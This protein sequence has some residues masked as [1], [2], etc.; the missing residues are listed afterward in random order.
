MQ[1][2]DRPPS[3]ARRPGAVRPG[4]VDPQAF[5]DLGDMLAR[6]A[7]S[8]GPRPAVALLT[9]RDPTAP[10]DQL[11]YRALHDRAQAAASLLLAALPPGAPV[12]I[13]MPT[14]IGTIVTF[15]GAVL[16]GLTPAILPAP[17]RGASDRARAA[18]DRLSTT[19]AHLRPGPVGLCL[20]PSDAAGLPP[21]IAAAATATLAIDD[22]IGLGHGPGIADTPPPLDPD[23]TACLQFTSGSTGAPRGVRLSHRAILSN[24]HDIGQVFRFGPG[25][26]AL[27][28]LPLHHDMGLMGHLILPLYAGGTAYLAAPDWFSRDPL[29]WL[30]AIDR[31]N[32]HGSG[33]PPFAYDLVRR[34]LSAAADAGQTPDIDLSRWRVAHIG[35]EPVHPDLLHRV[36]GA[37]SHLG[38]PDDALLPC[39]G[40]AEST[41]FC[42][43]GHWTPPQGGTIRYRPPDGT[44]LRIA[45]PDTGAPRPDGD[46]GE[47]HLAS[48]SL[49]SGHTGADGQAAFPRSDGRRWLK[50]GDLGRIGPDGLSIEGRLSNVIVLRGT[51]HHAEDLEA[52]LRGL[53]D[54]AGAALAALSQPGPTGEGLA[55]IVETRATP[56]RQDSLRPRI[57]A[58]LSDHHDAMPDRIA[59]VPPGWLPRTTSGKLRRPDIAQRLA[60]LATAGAA[61]PAAAATPPPDPAEPIAIIGL[62][63][64]FPGADD[65][66]AFW[67]RLARGD[68]LV[69]DI[70][71]DRWDRDAYFD[72]VPATPGK[73]NGKRGGFIDRPDLFDAAFFG[74]APPEAAE[75]D[76]QQRLALETAWRAF[77]D[78]GLTAE[79]L[80][81]S[82][83][84]V[85]LGLST[86]DYTYLQI[87]ARSDLSRLS[88]WSGLGATFSIAANR[89]SYVCDLRGPSVAVDTACS[90]SATA[91]HMAVSALRRGECDQAVAGGVNLILTPGTSIALAQFGM[92]SSD[93]ACKV[94]DAGADG[95]VR[96]EGCG[97]VVLKPLSRARAD[98]D[99]IDAVIL[100][101]A[102]A[103][104]GRSAGITAPNPDAQATLIARALADAGLAPAQIGYVEAHGTGTALGDPAELSVID[105]IYGQATG[106]TCRVGSV[107]A[108]VGHLEAAAGIASLIKTIGIF[109]RGRV[110]PQIHLRDPIPSVNLAHGRLR[111]PRTEEPWPSRPGQTRRAALSSFGFGGALAHLILAEGDPP[112]DAPVPSPGPLL[113]P[114]SARDGPALKAYA[115]DLA[116]RLGAHPAP[117]AHVARTLARHRSHFDHRTALVADNLPD[118]VTALGAVGPDRPAIPAGVPR[119]AVAFPGQGTHRPGQG[120]GLFRRFDAFR[121]AIDQA[122]QALARADPDAPPLDRL[123]FDPAGSDLRNP[124]LAQPALLALCL[125]NAALWRSFGLRPDAVLG[126]SLGEVAAATV[127]GALT[128]A[129]AMAFAVARGRAMAEIAAPGAMAGIAL[130]DGDLADRLARWDLPGLA[131]AAVNGADI[132]TLSGPA[133]A[134]RQALER[135]TADG[136]AARPLDTAQA[137]HSSVID[138]ALPA[139]AAAAPAATPPD[140]PLIST[141]TGA[142]L[143]E[144]PDAAHWVAHARQPVRFERALHALSEHG[145]THLVELGPGCV[146]SDL[147][148][149]QTPSHP[150]L[151]GGPGEAAAALAVLGKLYEAGAEIDWRGAE[152]L[153]PAIAADLRPA[154]GLP[155]HPFRRQRHWFDAPVAAPSTAETGPQDWHVDWQPLPQGPHPASPDRLLAERR[156]NWLLLGDGGDLAAT[157]AARLGAAGAQVVHLSRAAGTRPR[158]WAPIGGGGPG[159]RRLALPDRPDADGLTKLLIDLQ[160]SQVTSDDAR[161]T[162]LVCGPLDMAADPAPS[163]DRIAADQ[164][165]HG[166]GPLTTL[167]TALRRSGLT[168]Q[169][170]ALTRGAVATGRPAPL[171]AAVHGFLA[172]LFLEH[173]DL[174]GGVI[175]LDP[176][177]P[178]DAPR[179]DGDPAAAILS[180]LADAS[181]PAIGALRGDRI[182]APRLA[183][184]PRQ[185]TAPLTLRPDGT[186]L[187]TG[188]LGGLGLATAQRLAERGA[189]QIALLSRSADPAA[190][191]RHADALTRIERA[192]ADIALVPCDTADPEVLRQAVRALIPGPRPLRGI[193]HAAGQ[194]WLG[195]IADC[196]PDRIA[197]TMRV[198]ADAA[199]I[200]HAETKD[201]PLDFFVLYSSVSGLW[202]SAELGH[203]T[204]ANRFLDALAHARRADGLTATSIRWGP[205]AD[206]GMSANPRDSHIV[207]T[208]GLPLI[209]PGTALDALERAV[210]SGRAVTLFAEFDWDRFRAFA[211][212]NLC[213]G[214]FAA[215]RDGQDREPAAGRIG[216]LATQARPEARATLIAAIRRELGTL[217]H[218]PSGRLV[219]PEERFN[220]LGIDSLSAISLALRVETLTGI[221]LEPTLAY[222]HP[223]MGDVA[224][225]VLDRLAETAP[226]Q[227]AP[228]QTAPA[229]DAPPKPGWLPPAVPD[230]PLLVAL[231]YAGATGTAYDTWSDRLG[232]SRH[233]LP[234]DPPGRDDGGPG[235]SVA[236]LGADLAR[237]LLAQDLPA[238]TILFGH[239]FGARIALD[240]AR[241]LDAAGHPPE[242]VILSGCSPLRIAGDPLHLLDDDG[243]RAQAAKHFGGLADPSTPDA[244]WDRMAPRLRADLARLHQAGPVGGPPLAAPLAV[245]CGRDDALVPAGQMAAWQD[246]AMGPLAIHLVPGGHMP[247]RDD[248]DA[249]FRVLRRLIA[250]ETPP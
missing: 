39:Y 133:D 248:P 5:T 202:G 174:R 62:A 149:H 218:L 13:A 21:D 16:A 224:D 79:T 191:H 245:L 229:P 105:A 121:D 36:H 28:W 138:P 165:R 247:F 220:L 27:G 64:R 197:R 9:G 3:I 129:E 239:S 118:L 182:L 246:H 193:V 86:S 198:K 173:P 184:A 217:V 49:A 227:T 55:I 231:P 161:W 243:L 147:A 51:N 117:L 43:A 159:V 228:A 88:A 56:D 185:P 152:G 100:G 1:D 34:R 187:V 104:D 98:G 150:T 68:D 22:R 142:R 241:A 99:R 233:L 73:M 47:I 84:G 151:P 146:L 135:L 94:F 221:P 223:T 122:A 102:L 181:P 211:D 120:A 67:D 82:A 157:L 81:G 32:I 139:I 123:L 235:G 144:A 166:I 145:I 31:L 186:Y 83:T 40:L 131:I 176:V 130:S 54:L 101:S 57:A 108:S 10:A 128:P 74:I 208:M 35:A 162:I 114:L 96:S 112:G 232:P 204:A 196:T 70:P 92:L 20:G 183:R 116:D 97:M 200:L 69:T 219:G 66:A 136:I 38:L 213:P 89:V 158:A 154:P 201:L 215:L 30:R 6:R 216:D 71:P 160:A 26:R 137:F 180:A 46:L 42:A 8:H 17:R 188:G 199:A 29:A 156:K 190:R 12:L 141:L 163:P 53:P 153:A 33:G 18:L 76:P 203:Y 249:Y 78:A 115:T 189:G 19:L 192:G 52:T 95:Y 90:S 63:C 124:R 77:E 212:F 2:L 106:T 107:K 127:A 44:T 175:D 110:P 75:M 230:G 93:G 168:G 242:A 179:P 209:P 194:N 109:R 210:A 214:L 59:F 222:T 125:A 15:L 65:P 58:A 207:T 205:W 11:S 140:L 50:T 206:I 126:H 238:R 113:L 225:L 7:R 80:A 178:Q 91:L 119:I 61:P 172:S 24:M 169:V 41:V 87:A 236:E 237:S 148:R 14:T 244:V 167:A 143:T 164:A 37:L 155:G 85:Y 195:R 4:T 25:D 134:V 226:A 111:I 23:A 72:P 171:G 45:D 234:V 177:P 250:P 132:T 103:Q 60:T 48:P 240:A 170:W